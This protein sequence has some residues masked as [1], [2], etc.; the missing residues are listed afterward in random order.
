MRNKLNWKLIP[1]SLKIVFVLSI[2]WTIGSFFAISQRYEQGLPFFGFYIYGIIASLI[3][4]ILDIIGPILFLYGVWNKKSW[5]L[6]IA[7]TYILI[8]ILNS[9]FTVFTFR[10]EFGTIQLLMLAI[11]YG[12]FLSIIYKNKK[13]FN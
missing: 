6:K 11:V 4:L 1:T 8:F 12:I 3:I 2:I 13:H 7:A 9:I 5:T 10:N